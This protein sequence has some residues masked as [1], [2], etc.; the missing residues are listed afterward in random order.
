MNTNHNGVIQP[1]DGH[2]LVADTFGMVT[3]GQHGHLTM[4]QF[5]RSRH[6]HSASH[7]VAE[8]IYSYILFLSALYCCRLTP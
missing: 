2:C 5:F 7:K 8:R 1:G 3:S 6:M 4:L